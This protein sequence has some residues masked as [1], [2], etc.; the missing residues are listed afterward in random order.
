M[1]W[2]HSTLLA[3]VSATVSFVPASSH[4]SQT[5]GPDQHLAT[6]L[7]KSDEILLKAVHTASRAAWQTFAAPDFFYLDEEG[8]VTYLD[9]FLRQL[10]PMTSKPLHRE[11]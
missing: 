11:D 3:I 8:G 5:V 7:R 2:L 6:Q 4:A 1:S 10:V 9:A